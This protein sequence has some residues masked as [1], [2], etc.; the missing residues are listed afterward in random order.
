M[1]Y[2]T[3]I[4]IDEHAK[5]DGRNH[6][7]PILAGPWYSDSRQAERHAKAML[8]VL[9]AAK[10]WLTARGGNDVEEAS[11]HLEF[12]LLSLQDSEDS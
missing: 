12:A 7:R 1:K 9:G 8:E 6:V 5:M 10:T 2:I 11:L 4:T 3:Q